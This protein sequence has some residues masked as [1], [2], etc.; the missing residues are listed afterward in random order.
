MQLCAAAVRWDLVLALGLGTM[1][2]AP[3]GPLFTRSMN[4]RWVVPVLGAIITV[5]GVLT[6]VLRIKT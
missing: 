1:M 5:L 6:L 3:V 4:S 2:A